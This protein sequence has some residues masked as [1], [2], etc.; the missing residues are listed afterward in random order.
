M[1]KL[2]ILLFLFLNLFSSDFTNISLSK[3]IRIVANSTNRNFV[4]SDSVKKDFQIFLPKFSLSNKTK[5]FNILKNILKVNNLDYK[6]VNN[7]VLI[8]KSLPKLPKKFI[9]PKLTTFLFKFN[10]LLPKDIKSFFVSLYPNIKYTILQNRII[11]FTTF[12]KFHRISSDL[13]LLDSS[14][15]QAKVNVTIISTNNDKLKN[16]GID[17]KAFKYDANYYISL[18]TSKVS[19]N[20]TLQSNTQFYAFLNFMHN[21]GFTKIIT[22]PIINLVDK[23]S[24]V[25]ESTTNIPFLVSTTSTQNNTTVTRNS[26]KYKNVGLKV[27]FS[28][29]IVMKNHIECDLNIFIQSILDNSITPVVS[30]KHIQTHI[31][32]DKNHI[33]VLGGLNSNESYST[34][35]SIPGIEYIP[36]LG[37]LTTHKVKENKN[38]TFT[39]LI[40]VL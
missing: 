30:S 29:V 20:Q 17:F 2:I 37:Y 5:T 27:K 12:K 28:N 22:N 9:K 40:N 19:F 14:Y 31:I 4:I 13:H 24:A 15:L 21:K 23:K 32:L 10:Y 1:K 11:F 36:I 7:V 35:K 3:F 33:F 25:I 26:Y 38:L 34:V 16:S 18:I 39:V 8:F 6:I